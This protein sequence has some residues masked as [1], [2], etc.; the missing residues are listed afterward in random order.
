MTS[1]KSVCLAWSWSLVAVLGQQEP[2]SKGWL[3]FQ[4]VG[5]EKAQWSGKKSTGQCTPEQSWER[6][7]ITSI[8]VCQKSNTNK[9]ISTWIKEACVCPV[10]HS[11]WHGLEWYVIVQSHLPPITDSWMTNDTFRYLRYVPIDRSACWLCRG[12]EVVSMPLNPC[13]QMLGGFCLLCCFAQ[14]ILAMSQPTPAVHRPCLA[15]AEL[16]QCRISPAYVVIAQ[17]TLLQHPYIHR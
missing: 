16:Q 1:H 15:S 3:A 12:N 6:Y 5:G 7:T 4:L 10:L 11:Q 14:G 17:F 8:D 9:K 2:H 13:V